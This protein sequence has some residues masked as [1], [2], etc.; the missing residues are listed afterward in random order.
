MRTSFLTTGSFGPDL[1]FGS[2]TSPAGFW[3]GPALF[4]LDRLDL[5]SGTDWSPA[6]AKQFVARAESPAQ[7]EGSGSTNAAGDIPGDTSTT[8]TLAIGGTVVDTIEVSGDQDWF[9]I[10]LV[11]GQRYVFTLTGTGA[12]PLDDPYLEIMD[13]GGTQVRY[14]DDG[15]DGL[16]SLLYFTP[17]TS[18][19]YY[20]NAH[21][22]VDPD[23]DTTSTGQYTLTAAEAPPLGEY[24]FDQIADYLI[25]GYWSQQS[26]SDT[27]ITYNVQD[28]S[29]AQATLARLAL[30]EWQSV[31]SLVFTEVTTPGAQIIFTSIDTD[32]PDNP[33]EAATSSQVSGGVITH[34]DINITDGWYGG[35]TTLNSYTYQTYLHEIGHALGLGHA[36][37][38]NSSATYGQ[39]NIYVN[40]NWSYTVMSYFDQL[41][42]DFGNYRFVLGPQIAD[43][44]AIQSLYGANPGGTRAGNTVYGFNSTESDIND[45]S[46]FV[47]VDGGLTFTGPYSYAIYDTGG[48]DTIDLSGYYRD[49]ELSLVPETF[50]SVGDRGV[51]SDPT[52]TNIISIMRGTIIENAIGGTGNDTITGNSANNNLSGNNGNDTL[53]GGTGNDRI[54]GDNGADTLLGDGGADLIFG[55]LGNDVINGGNGNDRLFG[56]DGIDTLNGGNGNDNLNGGN[57]NDT[58]YGLSGQDTLKGGSGNDSLFGGTEDD[59]LS[60]DAGDDTL[61]GDAGAD[62]IAGGTGL[63]LIFGGTEDDTV[64]GDGGDDRLFGEDGADRLYGDAGFDNVSGGDGDDL[65][66]GGTQ[67]DNLRGGAGN[68]RLFGE[69]GND[70]LI[71]DTGDDSINGGAGRDQIFGGAGNDTINGDEDNDNISGDA[72]NDKL[73]GG[74]GD[75]KLK[76]AAGIDALFGGTGNDLILGGD[77][78]DTINGNE[79]SDRLFGESGNDVLDGGTG[80]DSMSGGLGSDLFIYRVQ[81][82]GGNDQISDFV[83]GEDTI[84]LY[85]SG[86]ADFT[87]LQAAIS[88]SGA[89]TVITFA[90][91]DTL[92]IKGIQ[93]ANLS[94][95]DFQFRTSA[96]PAPDKPGATPA[97]EAASTDSAAQAA[98]MFDFSGLSKDSAPVME[99]GDPVFEI[100][101]FV[102][103]QVKGALLPLTFDTDHTLLHAPFAFEPFSQDPELSVDGWHA[104]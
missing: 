60:G 54:S 92:L 59:S 78:G 72:G 48:N 99:A 58:L 35:I 70:R 100:G 65:I 85:D 82:D 90:N 87:A 91:G 45:W 93:S 8:A 77:D 40:D 95:S 7:A 28:L 31:T 39:D 75:D 13:A 20:V 34:A 94:A 96:E 103:S 10:T 55:G 36:G 80:D 25:N 24:T 51:N 74:D 42:A 17:G 21:G 16:N 68:D 66:F 6:W 86:Y 98:D 64:H 3:N 102:S 12:D 4:S 14:N 46:Q 76:G 38:Y 53:S 27:T 52:Y 2:V 101:D 50:S 43:I 49:Q 30:A 67:A 11:A 37:P 19:T 62:Q 32:D 81:A 26:W 84:R 29:A 47:T 79:G 23:T 15:G 61:N 89:N 57:D 9:K 104:A 1:T 69:I 88:Q 73:L 63:D 5:L 33:D 41:E 83:L 97:M 44:L 56:E 22:W 18:G 71:G